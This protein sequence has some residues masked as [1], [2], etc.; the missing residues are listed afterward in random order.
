MLPR[1]HMSFSG[2][3]VGT[4]LVTWANFGLWSQQSYYDH[5]FCK[6]IT[7]LAARLHKR[8]GIAPT[9]PSALIQIY[10]GTS[11]GVRKWLAT[12]FKTKMV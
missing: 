3:S 7:F 4:I 10:V 5:A 6:H 1:R 9:G 2:A 12:R 11:W 8:L